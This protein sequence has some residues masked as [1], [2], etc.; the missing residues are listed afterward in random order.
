[1]PRLCAERIHSARRVGAV[2][3]PTAIGRAQ[4]GTRGDLR[5]GQDKVDAVRVFG[6]FAE[7]IESATIH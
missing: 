2:R 3:M 5:R 1:M 4:T 7:E 6:N